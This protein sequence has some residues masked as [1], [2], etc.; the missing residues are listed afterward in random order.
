MPNWKKLIVSGSNATLNALNVTTSITGSDVKIDDWGSISG[1]LATLTDNTPDGSGTANYITKWSDSDSLTDSSISDDGSTINLFANSTG[2]TGVLNIYGEGGVPPTLQVSSRTNRAKLKIADNDTAINIIAEGSIGSFGFGSTS[3]ATNNLSILSSGNVGIGTSSPDRSLHVRDSAIVITKLEG[4]NQGSLLDLVNSNASQT[5]N[6]LRFTQGTTSKMAITHIADGTTK[7]YIQIGNNWA[8]GS[9]ILV[10]DGRTSNVGIGTTSP[11]VKLDVA[12]EIRTSSNYIA[13][14]ATLGSLSL[15]IS[16][17]ETGRLDNYNSALRLINFHATS[18]TAISGNADI[19]L[20]SVGSSN[21]KLSTAN[22]ERMRITSTGNVGIGTT[23]PTQLLHVYS[24]TSNPTG[25]GVQNNQRYYSVRSNNYSLVFTDETIGSERMRIDNNGNLGIG[26]TTP[27]AK[28]EVYSSGSTVF[29]VNGS[30]GQLFSITDSLS[31]SLFSVSDISGTPLFEVESDSTVTLGDYN[32]NTLVVTGSLVGIGK[33]DPDYKF[34]VK[35]NQDSSLQSGIVVERSA[36]TQ[37]AYFNVVGGAAN[38]VADTNIPIKLRHG[39]T[40]RLEI[41]TSGNSTFSGNLSTT[42]DL[43]AEDNIYLTD[44]GTVRAKLLLNASDRDNVELRAESLGSTMKFF[45]VGTE[46]LLLDASQNA[47]FAG[48]VHLDSDSG[49]LQFGDDND[50]QIYHN[51]A[52]GEINNPTGNFTIDSA[53][54]I[55]LDFDSGG[56]QLMDGGIK[57]GTF[58]K[59]NDDFHITANRQDGDIKFFGNDNGSS[60]TALRL[61][62]SDQGWAHFNTGI[63]V[64]NSAATSTFAGKVNIQGTPPVTANSNFNDLVITDSAHA[65]ISIFSGNSSDGAIYFGDT[66]ANNLGQIKYLHGSNTMTFA[67]NDTAPTLTFDAG[68]N[69]SFAGDVTVAGTITAQE[70]HTELVSAS[71]VYESGS[72][73]FGNT[74]DDNHDFTGSLNILAQSGADGI[75]LNRSSTA[76]ININNSSTRNEF[77]FKS[78]AGLRF[79]HGTDSSSPLFI[80][81]SGNVGIGT[82]SPLSRLTVAGGTGT[83]FNDGTL[84]VVGTIAMVSTSNLNPA[85]NTTS[86]SSRR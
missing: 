79:Y 40:T 11:G 68:L 20:K 42:G 26:T 57:F 25:I 38:I 15:R 56:T 69:A 8:T 82:S 24:G 76:Y 83:T 81:S 27:S 71:I 75:T 65:G 85:L 52:N 54:A 30:Q 41:N 46:A 37:K 86:K 84:Q 53:N 16:G 3:S 32:T 4:T 33:G 19:S 31:G 17:T 64:G 67:T 44:N 78:T 2:N 70:F 58:S 43:A 10:V 63:A 6:G 51:G 12:G 74:V 18:E 72:T 21:I 80:S 62:M 36:N 28:L 49:Q 47:T 7:G 73:K 22:T 35:D 66:D 50:M 61:D 13:D 39:S 9:E 77:N 5:Y 23:N 55:I 48:S 34:H 29:E 1:S 45:T 60:V 14:N 59:N